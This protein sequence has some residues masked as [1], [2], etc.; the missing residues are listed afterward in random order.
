MILTRNPYVLLK[1]TTFLSQNLKV[2]P[3]FLREFVLREFAINKVFQFWYMQK[4]KK[5]FLGPG[6][7]VWLNHFWEHEKGLSYKL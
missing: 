5:E 4:A 2:E 1:V 3:K 6:I 7:F